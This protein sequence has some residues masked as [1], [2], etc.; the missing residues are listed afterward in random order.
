VKVEARGAGYWRVT[1]YDADGNLTD[2]WTT[3]HAEVS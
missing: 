1:R 3:I 2:E